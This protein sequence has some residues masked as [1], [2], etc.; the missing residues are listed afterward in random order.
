M[1]EPGPNSPRPLLLHHVSLQ[2]LMTRPTAM[3]YSSEATSR[4]IPGNST[5]ASGPSLP[6]PV[7]LHHLPQRQWFTILLTVPF[8]SLQGSV[9]W[10][11]FN[12]PPLSTSLANN[13]HQPK[14]RK[15]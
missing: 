9:P 12:R 11:R 13:Y 7:P 8:C 10:L 5:L 3:F 2:W 14:L 4:V 1:R 6:P 15:T